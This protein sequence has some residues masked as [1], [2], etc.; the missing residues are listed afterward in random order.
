MKHIFEMFSLGKRIFYEHETKF[1]VISFSKL[2]ETKTTF[3]FFLMID[4]PPAS[5][6]NHIDHTASMQQIWR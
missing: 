3:F 5:K 4:F 1:T 2:I 6:K